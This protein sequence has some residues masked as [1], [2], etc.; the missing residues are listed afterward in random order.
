M[1]APGCGTCTQFQSLLSIGFYRC[2]ISVSIGGGVYWYIFVQSRFLLVGE[3][4]GLWVIL[5][6]FGDW[7]GAM[8]SRGSLVRDVSFF[9]R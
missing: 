3:S 6:E 1:A 4:I 9:S 7:S 8:S 5:L 2:E